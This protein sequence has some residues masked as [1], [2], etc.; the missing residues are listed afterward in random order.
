VSLEEQLILTDPA[1]PGADAGREPA[2]GARDVYVAK[3]LALMTP[4]LMLPYGGP[5]SLPPSAYG[6]ERAATHP[7]L[8]APLNDGTGGLLHFPAGGREEDIDRL[9]AVAGVFTSNTD[10]AAFL[11]ENG[12]PPDARYLRLLRLVSFGALE[13]FFGVAVKDADEGTTAL[14]P[15]SLKPRDALLAFIRS[16]TGAWDGAALEQAAAALQDRPPG[17]PRLGFGFMA[18]NPYH[19]VC[20]IWSRLWFDPAGRT[21]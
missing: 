16:E 17:R 3:G 2:P 19:S 10:Y 11:Y 18:E 20:R 9:L 15:Q 5:A 7:L 14:E 6:G 8:A 1:W 13:H 4:T 12:D 21:D